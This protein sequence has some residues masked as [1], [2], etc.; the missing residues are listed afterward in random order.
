MGVEMKVSINGLG[1]HS[2]VTV[3]MCSVPR[4]G[5]TVQ[6][7]YANYVVKNVKYIVND[8]DEPVVTIE[9]E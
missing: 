7:R 3:E 6:Y 9:C 8:S 4:V 2:D 1:Y 5:E